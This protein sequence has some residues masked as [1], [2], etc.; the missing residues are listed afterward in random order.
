LNSITM[1]TTTYGPALQQV[2]RL[3]A[4]YKD[5]PFRPAA[6]VA[7]ANF[8]AEQ[9]PAAADALEAFGFIERVT[10][11]RKTYLGYGF[12]FA[13]GADGLDTGIGYYRLTEEPTAEYRLTANG[14]DEV[15]R[16]AIAEPQDDAAAAPSQEVQALRTRLADALHAID[17]LKGKLAGAAATTPPS[18]SRCRQG[19]RE[20]SRHCHRCGAELAATD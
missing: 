14:K 16:L 13:S 20:N 18:C 9:A 19:C 11:T 10:T 2:L 5:R 8:P 6:L 15:E 12:Q 3:A 7:L 1:A 17:E 4:R